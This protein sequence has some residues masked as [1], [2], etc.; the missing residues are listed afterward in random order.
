MMK[1][2]EIAGYMDDMSRT[3]EKQMGNGGRDELGAEKWEKP[4]RKVKVT[5]RPL[6]KLY[7]IKAIP[8]VGRVLYHLSP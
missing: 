4:Y 6:Q 2:K 1:I 7:L 3:M 5:I 8:G